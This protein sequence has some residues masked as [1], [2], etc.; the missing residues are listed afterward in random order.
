M[1]LAE[2]GLHGWIVLTRDKR[3]RYRVLE[4][5]ALRAA[6]VKA[7]VFT[8]G[9]VGIMDTVQILVNALPRIETVCSVESAPFIYHIGVSGIPVRMK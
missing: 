1:W 2:C 4:R 9:N 3:I 6:G 8:G 7:F 5:T